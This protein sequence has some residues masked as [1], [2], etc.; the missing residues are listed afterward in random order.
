MPT[1]VVLVV[2]HMVSEARNIVSSVRRGP[3][4]WR[5]IAWRSSRMVQRDMDCEWIPN[6]MIECE[7]LAC[8]HVESPYTMILVS[9]VSG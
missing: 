9:F 6:L 8:Q 3:C 7:P 2:R 5:G 4:D 1:I